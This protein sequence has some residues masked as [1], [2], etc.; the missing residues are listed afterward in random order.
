MMRAYELMVI[1]DGDLDEPAAQG[2]VKTITERSPQA[3][4]SVHGKPDWW[5]KRRFA[6]EINKKEDGY[7]VVFNLVAPG[8]ASTTSSAPCASRTTSSATSSSACPTPRPRAAAWRAPRPDR[9]PHRRR[10]TMA[11]NTVTLV[12]NLTREPELRFTKAA[13]GVATFG[14]AVNRRYQQNGEWQEKTSF[15]NVTAWGQLGENAAAS[16]TKGARVIVNGR[17]E[18]R[19]YETRDGEKRTSS[20]R[21]RRD[22]PQPAL[23]PR[24]GRAHAPHAHRW[25]RRLRR[26]QRRR[27][28]WRLRSATPVGGRARRPRLRRRRAVLIAHRYAS[29]NS[30]NDNDQ[31]EEQGT[32][33]RKDNTKKFKKKTSIL[34]TEQVDYVDYKDVNLLQRFVSDRS[35]IRTA[36][37][38]ATTS[39]SSATSPRRSR[40]PARWRCCPTP[41]GSSQHR[42]GRPPRD[43]EDRGERGDATRRPRTPG[44]GRRRASTTDVEADVDDRRRGGGGLSMKVILRTDIDDVGKRG[45]ICDVADGYARNYLLPGPGHRGHRRRGRPGRAMRRARD[46]RDAAGPRVGREDRPPLVAKMITIT[47]KAGAEGGCSARSPRPT[48]PRRRGPDRHRRSTASCSSTSHQGARHPQRAREAP[49]PTWSSRSP[50]RSSGLS[51]GC[52]PPVPDEPAVPLVAGGC[53]L[54]VQALAFDVAGA[55]CPVSRRAVHRFSHSNLT[56]WH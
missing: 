13:G 20:S 23:G 24:P 8:G 43:R 30:R 29:P 10:T 4:G 2:W 27:L 34:V 21:R 15:F 54:P 45:D 52:R 37:S 55:P 53:S 18:Q 48:S 33:A 36:G 44:R 50:S 26:L 41:S 46:L 14:V 56:G 35:K 51:S 25:R 11:D 42:A 49:Q 22:R 38:G 40:T 31:Q 1:L 12:G 7:Y 17:L 9:P 5:G 28:R 39:S 47:A 19:E 32:H 3:G 16:L 6:Y